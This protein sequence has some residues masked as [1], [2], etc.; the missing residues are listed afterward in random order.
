M[1]QILVLASEFA[2]EDFLP[3]GSTVKYSYSADGVETNRT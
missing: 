3:D 2:D 1:V